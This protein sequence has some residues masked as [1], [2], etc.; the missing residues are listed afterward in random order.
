M[1][2]Y[3]C[4]DDC[5]TILTKAH[6]KEMLR[7]TQLAVDDPAWA[8]TC[9]RI[10]NEAPKDGVDCSDSAY[11]NM[12]KFITSPASSFEFMT[13]ID[14]QSELELVIRQPMFYEM[15]RVAMDQNFT[16]EHPYS[17]YHVAS[18]NFRGP[19]TFNDW[20]MVNGTETQV[21][22]PKLDRTEVKT[23]LR[24]FQ[25]RILKKAESFDSELIEV[26]PI[27]N[28]LYVMEETKA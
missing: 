26:F 4:V 12:T 14:I 17:R 10:D 23:Y 5:L 2:I 25:D 8:E 27:S 16:V 3:R 13:D 6:I 20:E 1:L 15:M 19:I 7:F 9:A 21:R 18:L 11:Y 24:E 22:G 28:S